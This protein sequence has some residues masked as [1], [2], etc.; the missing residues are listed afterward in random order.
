[1]HCTRVLRKR[2]GDEIIIIDGKGMMCSAVLTLVN[3]KNCEAK[4]KDIIRQDKKRG[5]YLHIGIAP[6]KNISRLE[7][8]LEKATEIGIDE[9]TPLLCEHS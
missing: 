4:I 1:M 3:K 5:Y 7:W 8:F 6:T 9:I 2:V